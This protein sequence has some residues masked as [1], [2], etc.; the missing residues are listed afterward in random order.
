MFEIR[1]EVV[2]GIGNVQY[3]EQVGYFNCSK[4]VVIKH[5]I[6][7]YYNLAR[8]NTLHYKLRGQ[9]YKVRYVFIHKPLIDVVDAAYFAK[10]ETKL[11]VAEAN[12]YVRVANAAY[13][14]SNRKRGIRDK[15]LE[16][17]PINV[18]DYLWTNKHGVDEDG[19]V[20][21]VEEDC[22]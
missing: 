21:V 4:D 17:K 6:V 1:K 8:A 16:L 14:E 13:K 15:S 18:N 11:R 5:L 22:Y 9:S 2:N 19:Y 10:E 12:D 20:L 7:P 3:S